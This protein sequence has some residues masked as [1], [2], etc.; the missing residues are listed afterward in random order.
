VFTAVFPYSIRVNWR[1][2]ARTN[3]S[4][5]ASC[6]I[7]RAVVQHPSSG[8][9]RPL[10][11]AQSPSCAPHAAARRPRW[12]SPSSPCSSPSAGLPRPRNASWTAA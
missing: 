8:D 11:V 4:W 10:D 5:L 6:N 9:R 1:V 12:S 7:R 2:A 3:H